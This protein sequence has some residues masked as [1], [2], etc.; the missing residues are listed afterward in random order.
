MRIFGVEVGTNLHQTCREKWDAYEKTYRDRIA[1]LHEE[2]KQSYLKDAA[3]RDEIQHRHDAEI[4]RL[5]QQYIESIE[6]EIQSNRSLVEHLASTFDSMR[7]SHEQTVRI[8]TDRLTETESINASLLEELRDLRASSADRE[9]GL[10]NRILLMSAPNPAVAQ[11]LANLNGPV[12]ARPSVARDRQRPPS[13][14]GQPGQRQRVG[15]RSDAREPILTPEKKAKTDEDARAPHQDQADVAEAAARVANEA[16]VAE[17]ESAVAESLN[18]ALEN[19]QNV[20]QQRKR[21]DEIARK[22]A[23]PPAPATPPASTPAV[24]TYPE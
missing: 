8:L 21:L 20:D 9:D 23:A 22:A 10:M 13:F 15:E 11:A 5:T 19:A 18:R 17:A 7:V 3:E 1:E 2:K 12:P 4:Q 14:R 24:T 6:G 16:E